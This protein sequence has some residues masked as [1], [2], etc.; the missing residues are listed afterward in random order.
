[1]YDPIAK[2]ASVYGKTA[3]GKITERDLGLNRADLRTY[4][5]NQIEKL[6]CIARFAQIDTEAQKL[7]DEATW[8]NAEYVAIARNCL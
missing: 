7:L 5:S 2:L 6:V 4:R 3:R 1:M 8:S